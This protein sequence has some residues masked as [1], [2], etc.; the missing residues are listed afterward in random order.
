MKIWINGL[1]KND[2]STTRGIGSYLQMA[3]ESI[4]SFGKKYDLTLDQAKSNI[5]IHPGFTPFQKLELKK[6]V[7]NLVV[8]HDVIPLKYKKKFKVGLKG[9]IRKWLN[10]QALQKAKGVITDTHVVIQVLT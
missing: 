2:L 3:K 7:H 1:A 6:N 8:I 4:E 10:M 9:H 5:V